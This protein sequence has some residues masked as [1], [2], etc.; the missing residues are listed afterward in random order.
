MTL[1]IIKIYSAKESKNTYKLQS[2]IYTSRTCQL[3]LQ[4][5]N[6]YTAI[7]QDLQCKSPGNY[8]PL[9]Q[10]LTLKTTRD[11]NLPKLVSLHGEV[12]RNYSVTA[13]KIQWKS[14]RI[15]SVN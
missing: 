8:S 9:T 4:L 13:Q 11:L 1:K 15:Y 5:P 7:V 14:P 3:T 10:E 2:K 12:P 6:N